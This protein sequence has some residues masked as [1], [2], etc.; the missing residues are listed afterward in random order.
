LV[1]DETVLIRG[2]L[3]TEDLRTYYSNERSVRSLIDMLRGF[4]LSKSSICRLFD[5]IVI[6]DFEK[7]AE[8]WFDD[9]QQID[10]NIIFED[11]AFVGTPR[12]IKVKSSP[13]K[14]ELKPKE[15][16]V[17]EVVSVEDL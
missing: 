1:S 2:L 6:R 13:P 16:S 10:V 15:K 8:I 4:G 12:K 17:A 11:G 9:E 3:E 7:V 14:E 5:V